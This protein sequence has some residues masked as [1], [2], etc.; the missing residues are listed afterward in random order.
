M[1]KRVFTCVS[2][3]TSDSS[4]RGKSLQAPEMPPS[5]SSIKYPGPAQ[6]SVKSRICNRF[7][8]QKVLKYNFYY[9]FKSLCL[10]HRTLRMDLNQKIAVFWSR[11]KFRDKNLSFQ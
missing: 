8:E 5:T 3:G 9:T 7:K 2:F 4:F 6:P 1:S 10:S 11:R